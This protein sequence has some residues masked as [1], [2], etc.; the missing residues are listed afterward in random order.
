MPTFLTRMAGSLKLRLSLAACLALALGIGSTT[1]V[2]EQRA[3]TD[4]LAAGEADDVAEV[5]RLARLLG[6]Q[7]LAQQRALSTAAAQLPPAIVDDPAALAQYLH[8]KPTTRSLFDSLTVFGADGRARLLVDADGAHRPDSSIADRGYFRTAMAEQRPVIS[9]ALPSRLTGEWVVAMLH[10]LP[11]GRGVLS[12]ALRLRS[13]DLLAGLADP[14]PAADGTAA[15]AGNSLL[16]VTDASG[17]LL[18]HPEPQRIGNPLSSEP[19]LAAAVERWRQ[20]GAPAEPGGL[21][22]SDAQMQVAVAAVPGPDWLVWRVR[23]RSEVL[24]P[25]VRAQHEAMRWAVGLVAVFS[26][27]LLAWIARL[28][29]PLTRLQARAEHLFDGAVDPLRGWPEAGG[30]IGRLEAVLRRVGGE[31]LRLEAANQQVLQRLQSVMAAAPVGIAFTRDRRYELVSAHW[32]RLF[33]LDEQA[34]LGQPAQM[35]F[36]S[37]E[38]YL[39]MGRQVGEAFAGGRPYEGDWAM[40][41]GD[42]SRFWGRLRAQ[43]VAPGDPSAGTIWTLHDVTDEIAERERLEWSASHDPL[44]GLANR[45]AL[46]KR[47]AAMFAALPRSRPAALVVFDLD[48]FKPVNDRHGHAAGDAMLRAVAA[49]AAARVRAGDLL[50]RLGGDEFAVVLERCPQ[51]VAMRVADD[52]RAAVTAVQ[53]PWAGERLSVGASAGVAMLDDGVADADAWLAAADRACYEAKAAGRGR[54]QAQRA[55]VLRVVGDGGG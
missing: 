50:V 2:L 43:P 22:F 49:A 45:A 13:R 21:A 1:A 16:A 46:D 10:P 18:A 15:P 47:V 8:G 31:R 9:E 14:A 51:D 34:L 37:N 42:G 26:L 20:A 54:V 32:C 41:R 12:G 5:A 44:T 27:A 23:P 52:L 38:D 53:L 17:S 36:A 4:T 55:P 29:Q 3:R 35:H 28:L 30:E 6:R 11:E 48:R 33:G 40:L 24:A 7:V 39:Q 25:L 19:G